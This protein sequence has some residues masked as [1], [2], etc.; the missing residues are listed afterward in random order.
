MMGTKGLSLLE[1]DKP[2][3]ACAC[4]EQVLTLAESLDDKLYRSDALGNI[5]LALAAM[6]DAHRGRQSSTRP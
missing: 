5:G 3:E 2:G 4:F 1:A 6:G